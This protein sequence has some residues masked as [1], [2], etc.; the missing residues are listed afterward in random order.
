MQACPPSRAGSVTLGD[1]MSDY[2]ENFWSEYTK[3]GSERWIKI[4][5]LDSKKAFNL[6]GSMYNPNLDSGIQVTELG[7]TDS[8]GADHKLLDELLQ[9]IADKKRILSG[10]G[11]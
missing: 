2:I 5:V 4:K 9:W 3:V 11:T 1:G 8:V 6:F 10:A 7:L